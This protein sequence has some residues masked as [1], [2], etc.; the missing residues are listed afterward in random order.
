M[1]VWALYSN[2]IETPLSL[3]QPPRSLVAWTGERS[4]T[5]AEVPQGYPILMTDLQFTEW[6]YRF[7]VHD[8]DI[9]YE[10]SGVHPTSGDTYT[11]SGAAS[12][13]VASAQSAF[14]ESELIEDYSLTGGAQGGFSGSIS[15]TQTTTFGTSSETATL[16]GTL[17]LQVAFGRYT[18]PTPTLVVPYYYRT[19]LDQWLPSLNVASAFGGSGIFNLSF[20]AIPSPVPGVGEKIVPVTITVNG[21]STT[22]QALILD[23]LNFTSFSASITPNTW[24][25][26]RDAN[27]A[28]PIW[29]SID[30]AKLLPNTLPMGS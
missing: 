11:I 17:T 29:N 10:L 9:A 6:L 4:T 25:E 24:W 13:T 7:K 20:S 15:G 27:G 3:I 2:S 18:L 12:A 8:F 5:Q 28:N 23:W 22:A 26:Y 16:N 14:E 21:E 1:R 19:D 30:G